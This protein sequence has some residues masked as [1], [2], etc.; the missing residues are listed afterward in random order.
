MT[1]VPYRTA[2][3]IP[4][5]IVP[6]ACLLLVSWAAASAG[7]RSSDVDVLHYA[8]D[9]AVGDDDDLV[10][11]SAAVTVRFLEPGVDEVTLDLIGR[12]DSTGMT[13]TSVRRDGG[14]VSFDHDG[15]QLVIAVTSDPEAGDQRTYTVDYHGVPADGLVISSN[16]HG[17]RTFFGDNWPERARHW[18]PCVDDLGDKAT[19]EFIVTAPSHY[20]VIANGLVQEETDLDDG[21][22]RTHWRSSRP[23]PTKVMVIGVARFAVQHVGAVDGIPVQSWTYP[24]DRGAGFRDFARAIKV[25]EVLSAR[26]GPFP[27]DKLANVQSTTRYGGME[28]ASA[29]FYGERTIKGDGSNEGLI[30]HEI[31]HQW[32]GDSVTEADWHHVWLSEGFATYLAQVYMEDVYGRERLVEGM[33]DASHAIFRFQRMRPGLSVVAKDISEPGRLL[34]ALSY[35]KGAWVL[36]MLR[37]EVGEVAFW[38]GLR[39]YYAT[40]RDRNATTGDLQRLMETAAGRPLDWFFD[41]WVRSA[42][43]PTIDAVWSFNETRGRLLLAVTQTQRRAFRFPIDVEIRLQSGAPPRRLRLDVRHRGASIGIDLDQ[44]PSEV[45]LDPDGWLLMES[46]IRPR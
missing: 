13:V 21:R 15:D 44:P 38:T 11:G 43:H 5:R 23:L 32:F 45:V 34:N 2:M 9:I 20:Q 27:Y 1:T 31:A 42:G 40:Y 37:R 3:S 18:L 14:A 4:H 16:A 35:Q 8:F 39:E 46:T 17:E 25:V 7:D 22:R 30:A 33:R 41:Q 29:I 19:V 36:H 10:R 12:G 6:L 24:G 28:N 26:L